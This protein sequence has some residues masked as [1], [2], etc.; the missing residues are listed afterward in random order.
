ML[1][2][3]PEKCSL[4]ELLAIYSPKEEVAILLRGADVNEI[5]EY[6]R[7]GLSISQ[8]AALTGFNRRT[9][10]KYLVQPQTPRYRPRP[11]RP[12]QLDPHQEYLQQR[13]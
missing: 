2:E 11:P 6:Q 1:K 3:P 9:V 8:I 10:R 7:Q 4:V 13:L 12:S 5:Q